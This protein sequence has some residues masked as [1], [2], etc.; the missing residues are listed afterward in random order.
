M[1]KKIL[2]TGGLGFMGSNLVKHLF[3]KYPDY[4]ISVLDSLTYAGDMKNLPDKIKGS[5]RFHFY[6]GTITNGQLTMGLASKHDQVVHLAAETHTSRSIYDN[7]TCYETNILGT[8]SL[9]NA[10]LNNKK[11][12]ERFIHISTSEVYGTAEKEPMDEEHPLNATTPYAVSKIGADRCVWSFIKTY[13]IPGIIIRP[14]NNYGPNQHLEKVIPRFITSALKNDSLIIHGD[15]SATRD[16]IYVEDFCKAI[17]K[18]MHVDLEKVKGQ[19]INVGT[20][21]ETSVKDISKII[22]ETIPSES[23]IIYIPQR[24]DYVKRHI[25]STEKAK[26]LLDWNRETDLEKGLEKTCDW[27]KN[28]PDWWKGMDFMKQVPIL[29]ENGKKEFY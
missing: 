15:G 2:V 13:D 12:I 29:T 26:K 11:N 6:H 22:L 21:K 10:V 14:F 7:Q 1:K 27:Y 16:W 20:G 17:D 18:S 5:E 28:N 25:S 19:V 23:E 24:P 4:E 3:N 9:A 8:H